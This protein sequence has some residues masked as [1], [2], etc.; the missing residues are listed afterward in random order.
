[1]TTWDGQ[2]FVYKCFLV[3]LCH[4][5]YKLNLSKTITAVFLLFLLLWF[6]ILADMI[7]LFL[8]TS[9]NTFFSF[10]YNFVFH[11]AL[12]CALWELKKVIGVK[13][14]CP[15]GIV[16]IYLALN[17]NKFFVFIY[18]SHANLNESGGLHLLHMAVES[19][20]LSQAK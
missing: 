13:K 1:M 11:F 15:Q 18:K 3:M 17:R 7:S 20:D 16:S 6:S 4:L 14:V 9:L 8:W 2:M 5:F 10:V 19:R 12:V